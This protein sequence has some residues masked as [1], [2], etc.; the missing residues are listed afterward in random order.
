VNHMKPVHILRLYC[1]KIRFNIIPLR[2][3]LP[4]YVFP[5][6]L[7]TEKLYAFLI[8]PMRATVLAHF[9]LLDLMITKIW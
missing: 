7:S 5:S 3:D 2:L 6:C 1:F 8:S 4:S 9:I